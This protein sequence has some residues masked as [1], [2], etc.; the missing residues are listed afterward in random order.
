M[1]LR[2]GDLGPALTAADG[3]FDYVVAHGVYSWVPAGVR[4]RLLAV[5]REVLAQPQGVAFI[6]YNTYPGC[7]MRRML[8]DMMK[9]HAAARGRP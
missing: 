3:P 2:Q 8:W 7:H 9:F 6:S 4:D 1:T 5:C